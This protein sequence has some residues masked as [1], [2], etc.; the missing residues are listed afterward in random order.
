MINSARGA[1]AVPLSPHPYDKPTQ[2]ALW[3]PVIP[4]WTWAAVMGF[5]AC[6]LYIGLSWRLG[7]ANSPVMAAVYESSVPQVRIAGSG[8]TGTANAG[9][10]RVPAT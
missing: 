10:E 4:L 9:L 6:L 1:Y 8:S 7:A 5:V 2:K 3:R